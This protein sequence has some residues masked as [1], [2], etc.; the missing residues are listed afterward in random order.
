MSTLWQELR[1]AAR[2]L[3]KSPGFL[4]IT[5]ITLALGIGANTAIFS[6]VQALIL[7]PPKIADPEKVV[8]IWRT[9]KN[10]RV[11][12]FLSYLDLQ[13]WRMQNRSF[14]QIAAYKTNGFTLVS[15]GQA[16][17]MDGLRVTANF[18]S[19]LKIKLFRGRDFQPAEEKQGAQGVVIVSHQFWQNR[20]GANEA[21]LGQQLSLDGRSLTIIG[22]L[23]PDFEFPLAP[24][25]TELLTTIAGEGQNLSERG[26][27]I[28][29]AIARLKV[30]VTLTEA[31]TELTAMAENL[32]QKYPENSR[33]ITAYPVPV[34]EQIVGHDVRRTL[35][36]L[37][38]AVGF[39]LLIACTNITNLLLV[40]ASLASSAWG[41]ILPHCGSPTGGKFLARADL[42]HRRRAPCALGIKRDSVFWRGSTATIQ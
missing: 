38:G 30:D 26:A 6:V 24:D 33:D 15:E 5:I 27:Q 39:I 22:I 42:R 35:W 7:T 8:T 1:Y 34:D 31:Q 12:G 20:L 11:E 25:H 17:E 37:L 4:V 28:L 29:K 3:W 36:L 21:A 2:M 23:P 14:E 9:P 13:D 40:R 19:I 10:E 41:R 16:E 18:L 32:S